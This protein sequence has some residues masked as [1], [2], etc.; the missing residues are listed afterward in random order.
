MADPDTPD[1]W[2]ALARQHEATA[3]AVV[4]SRIA[5]GQAVFHVG[6]AV[7][8]ALKAYIMRNERL[9]GWPSK[10][11][12]RDL[13]THDLRQLLSASGLVIARSDPTAPAWALVLQWDRNQAYDPQPIPRKVARQWVESAFGPEG[14]V[15]WVRRVCP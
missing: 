4:T 15:E 3:R 2:F 7:E 11:S 14:V 8:C 9:N 1:E 13:H 10:E 5:A 6:L 12:R